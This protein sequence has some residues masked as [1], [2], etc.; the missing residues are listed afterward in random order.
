MGNRLGRARAKASQKASG[1]AKPAGGA[2][3]DHWKPSVAPHPV[4]IAATGVVTSGFGFQQA[5]RR[6]PVAYVQEDLGQEVWAW[7]QAADEFNLAEG[8]L[9]DAGSGFE[10]CVDYPQLPGHTYYEGYFHASPS[11]SPSPGL[12]P[13]PS[14]TSPGRAAEACKAEAEAEKTARHARADGPAAPERS[15]TA[16]LSA[17]VQAGPRGGGAPPPA[18]PPRASAALPFRSVHPRKGM[19]YD[20]PAASRRLACFVE[21]VRRAN[22]GPLIKALE[23]HGAVAEEHTPLGTTGST[24]ALMRRLVA[25]L[26]QGCVPRGFPAR[27]ARHV[28]P[29]LPSPGTGRSLD[30]FCHPRTIHTHVFTHLRTHAWRCECAC[31]RVR[32]HACV[33]VHVHGIMHVHVHVRM[34][35]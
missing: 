17:G 26:R 34:P 22:N 3:A 15:G 2:V 14:G 8:E 9:L 35:M 10:R 24:T 18:P 21:S 16:T 30:L 33:C 6:L 20:K 5:G 19:A 7:L 11:S 25:L 1:V 28:L 32:V 27:F 31:V 29:V 4:A 13:G 23:A 12:A